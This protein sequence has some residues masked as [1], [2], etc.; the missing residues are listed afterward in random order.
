MVYCSPGVLPEMVNLHLYIRQQM[1]KRHL[2]G[3]HNMALLHLSNGSRCAL[4]ILWRIGEVLQCLGDL[5]HGWLQM[6]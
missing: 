2:Q 1:A 4:T 3:D 5:G 6:V